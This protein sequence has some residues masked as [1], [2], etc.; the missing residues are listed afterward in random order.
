MNYDGPSFYKKNEHQIKSNKQRKKRPQED[1][2]LADFK[3]EE[4][5]I[6]QLSKENIKKRKEKEAQAGNYFF[7]S[8]YIPKSL[9]NLDG[10]NK[11][12]WDTDLILEIE[13]RLKKDPADYLLFSDSQNKEI[14]SDKV[15]KKRGNSNSTKTAEELRIQQKVAEIENTLN[16]AALVQKEI[17]ADV[18]KPNTGL[19]R[20]LS[21][22]I[23]E[24]AV[25]IKNGKNNLNSLFSNKEFKK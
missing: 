22:I 9:Q 12:K 3:K 25:E 21:K 8:K 16:T 15:E 10:W 4:N 20:T 11:E 18:T 7:R 1:A 14:V 2:P 13:S 17:T 19:H 23:A 6:S 5:R 24:D